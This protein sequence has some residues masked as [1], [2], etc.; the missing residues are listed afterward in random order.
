MGLLCGYATRKQKQD[1]Y[2]PH[3]LPPEA[4]PQYG[5]RCVAA[6]GTAR[7]IPVRDIAL[8]TAFRRLSAAHELAQPAR[9]D[10][11][12][13]FRRTSKH[14]WRTA[15][16]PSGD[17]RSEIDSQVATRIRIAV[18]AADSSSGVTIGTARISRASRPSPT[19]CDSGA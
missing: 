4:A 7:G 2:G 10:G 13:S 15:A 5:I 3:W 16:L 17:W 9:F 1:R 12:E 8:G 19:R 6:N 14:Q 11:R 18:V